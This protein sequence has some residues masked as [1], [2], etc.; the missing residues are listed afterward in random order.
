MRFARRNDLKLHI[1]RI[2]DKIKTFHCDFEGC[3]KSFFTSSELNR[4]RHIHTNLIV[5]YKK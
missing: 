3:G 5:C 1:N 4:H 2:H